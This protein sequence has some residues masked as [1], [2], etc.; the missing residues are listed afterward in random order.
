MI[1]KWC[2]ATLKELLVDKSCEVPGGAFFTKKAGEDDVDWTNLAAHD[3]RFVYRAAN[4]ERSD[5]KRD[6]GAVAVYGSVVQ[7]GIGDDVCRSGHG[8]EVTE[9]GCNWFFTQFF[10]PRDRLFYRIEFRRRWHHRENL[11][12]RVFFH[13]KRSFLILV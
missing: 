10:R 5:I 8:G 12:S 9:R 3:V 11:V 6:S 1:A 4:R 13:T 2:I 7:Y